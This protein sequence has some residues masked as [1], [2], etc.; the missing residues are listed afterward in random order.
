MFDFRS[1]DEVFSPSRRLP[2]SDIVR[3]RAPS[4]GGVNT[5]EIC[6]IRVTDRPEIKRRA[7]GGHEDRGRSPILR[8]SRARRR[9]STPSASVVARLSRWLTHVKEREKQADRGWRAKE[10][11]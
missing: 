10:G 3:K 7:A 4:N 9:T 2:V 6:Q 5:Q 11:R 8:H 1:F